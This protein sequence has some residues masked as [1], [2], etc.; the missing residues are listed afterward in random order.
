MNFKIIF[1]IT[2]LTFVTACE[3]K[4]NYVDIGPV[5]VDENLINNEA[6]PNGN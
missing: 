4:G 5:L 2:L 1:L 6:K 3:N